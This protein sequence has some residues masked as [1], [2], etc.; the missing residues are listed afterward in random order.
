MGFAR[1][2]ARRGGMQIARKQRQT[3]IEE[4]NLWP[5]S[6]DDHRCFTGL[7]SGMSKT[8]L[9]AGEKLVATAHNT[10]ALQKLQNRG[11][12]PDPLLFGVALDVTDE[13]QER[14]AVQAAV[15]HLGPSMSL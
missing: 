12:E 6:L 9:A 10:S 7:R 14:S 3:N 5:E 2:A 13:A 4:E 8:V 1:L 15:N 11:S